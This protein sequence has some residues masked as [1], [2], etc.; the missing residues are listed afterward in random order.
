MQV[1]FSCSYL[2]FV[3]DKPLF[4]HYIVPTSNDEHHELEERGMNLPEGFISLEQARERLGYLS[5]RTVYNKID[6]GLLTKY[7]LGRFTCLKSEQV[8]QLRQPVP[9]I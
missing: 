6:E 2:H 1:L 3:L 8:E 9:Q 4:V 7:K 5:V